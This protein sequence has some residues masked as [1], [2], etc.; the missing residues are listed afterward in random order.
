M[1]RTW[2]IPTLI[3]VMALGGYLVLVGHA[4]GPRIQF[5]T[6]TR[7][8]LVHHVAADGT[9]EALETVKVGAE[10]SG[11]I[12]EVDT[13]FNAIVH[14]GQVLARFD[15]TLAQADVAEA[16]SAISQA[17]SEVDSV[18]VQL[19]SLKMTLNRAQELAAHQMETPADLDVA[20]TDV[21]A[22]EADLREKEAALTQAKASLREREATLAKTVIHSPIDG[23]VIARNVDPGQTVASRVEAPTLFEIAAGLTHMQIVAS[24]DEAD[25][26]VVTAGEPVSFTVEAYPSRTFSGTVKELRVGPQVENNVVTYDTVVDTGNQNLRLRPGMT[27]TV[28]I[29]TT[30]HNAVLTVPDTAVRFAPAREFFAALGQPAPRNLD[31]LTKAATRLIENAKGQVWVLEDG[32][33]RPIPVRI[34]LWDAASATIE[35]S[36]PEAREGLRVVSGF[37]L[38]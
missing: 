35:I 3:L 16:R 29:E 2:A 30:R 17:Q 23:I 18:R 6:V 12:A 25:A 14:K 31:D 11:T 24:I 21:E 26:G 37:S 27:A 36:G 15:P 9:V 19:D 4:A 33:L 10:V 1:R 34:G 7:G 5:A 32:R 38:R 13:D 8:D 22:A 20:R 28:S